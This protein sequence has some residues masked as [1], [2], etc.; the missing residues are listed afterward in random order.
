MALG[1]G[2]Y[3]GEEV[4][5]DKLVWVEGL[6]PRGMNLCCS[7]SCAGTGPHRTDQHKLDVLAVCV[8]VLGGEEIAEA[9]RLRE[10]QHRA[11]MANTELAA[12]HR[13]EAV[14]EPAGALHL[15]A[16]VASAMAQGAHGSGE[17]AVLSG[18]LGDGGG[19]SGGAG[20]GEGML[21]SAAFA[22]VASPGPEEPGYAP[23]WRL[24]ESNTLKKRSEAL[25]R[26]QRVAFRIIYAR[27]Q[28][29]ALTRIRDVLGQLGW[30]KQRLAEEAANPVLL[31]SEADRPGT[32]PTKHLKPDNVRTRPLPLYRD[33]N[34]TFHGP[35]PPS[36][37]TDFD[38]LG[39]M[40]PRVP[41]EYRLL[42][43]DDEA[44]PGLTTYAPPLAE[45]PLESG[46]AEERG[47]G[48]GPQ[49]SGA[50]L[51]GGPCD[52]RNL[53]PMPDAMKQPPF[54]TLEVGNRYTE[55]KVVALPEP[56]WG[57]DLAYAVQPAL[58]AATAHDSTTHEVAASGS[59]RALRG[60]PPS[61]SARWLPRKDAWGVQLSAEVVPQLLAGPDPLDLLRDSLEDADKPAIRIAVSERAQAGH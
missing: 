23:A 45:Q 37:Y 28:K 38:E 53:P 35:L 5:A 19:S 44:F 48:E 42:G 4:G 25:L 11:H 31:V 29:K 21:A 51:P 40:V 50:L 36:D 24:I 30:D 20:G 61:L 18:G 60:A 33:V 52:V 9:Q 49:P 12:A 6:R 32:A 14:L 15:P 7:W 56:S 43:Y 47:P 39:P 8:Q 34:F 59:V 22:G 10:G 46:A 41:L 57:M 58:Y 55:D 16:G 26:L 2:V 3:I 27:R 13:L 1:S 54:T 17:G